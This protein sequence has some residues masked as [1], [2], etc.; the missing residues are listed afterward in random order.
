MI[1]FDTSCKT[2]SL[3]KQRRTAPSTP[4]FWH[5]E[6]ASSGLVLRMRI[7]GSWAILRHLPCRAPSGSRPLQGEAGQTERNGARAVDTVPVVA[8]TT[9]IDEAAV[10]C[11]NSTSFPPSAAGFVLGARALPS[12]SPLPRADWD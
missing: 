9:S 4:S 3:P 10:Q 1:S 6:L 2:L 12:D 11:R 7:R 8:A 5:S